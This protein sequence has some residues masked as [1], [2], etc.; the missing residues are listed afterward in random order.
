M[1]ELGLLDRWCLLE[2][3]RIK[4]IHTALSAKHD[5]LGVALGIELAGLA[6]HTAITTTT[7]D[8]LSDV[9]IRQ[10]IQRTESLLI[11][12]APLLTQ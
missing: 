11:D 4:H 3:D 8:R 6:R 9:L 10:R 1:D 7:E 2:A 12:V 5:V